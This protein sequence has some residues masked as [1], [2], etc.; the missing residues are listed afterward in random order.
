MDRGT[1]SSHSQ[2]HIPKK[3][4]NSSSQNPTLQ[5]PSFPLE[6][7]NRHGRR[8][9][10]SEVSWN[11]GWSCSLN[12]PFTSPRNRT[13]RT[14]STPVDRNIS[15]LHLHV[16]VSIRTTST[17][18]WGGP[19]ATTHWPQS[20]YH[21]VHL[22]PIPRLGVDSRLPSNSP[23]NHLFFFFY[24]RYLSSYLFI[25]IINCD[26][27]LKCI[28]TTSHPVWIQDHKGQVQ[29]FT[30]QGNKP[31]QVW[32]PIYRKKTNTSG[33]QDKITL[34]WIWTRFHTKW[35]DWGEH[36]TLLWEGNE[37]GQYLIITCSGWKGNT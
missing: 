20:G 26:D 25:F 23:K 31:G 4:T 37:S 15:L 14:Y 30:T 9:P 13:Q 10:S 17:L 2:Y 3:R 19:R 34:Y 12:P 33:H 6:P 32:H 36:D 29:P 21:P 22:F 16:L 1:F 27:L 35:N 28:R 11:Y 7:R 5:T 8:P 18:S 24:S